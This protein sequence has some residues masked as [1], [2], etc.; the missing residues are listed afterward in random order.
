MEITHALIPDK[1]TLT[2]LDEVDV[3]ARCAIN[4]R[5]VV[6][7]QRL[8]SRENLEQKSINFETALE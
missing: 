8:G 7:S 3:E 6:S 1:Y 2:V 5:I 4:L